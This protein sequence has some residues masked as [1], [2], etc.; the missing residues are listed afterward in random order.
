MGTAATYPDGRKY[1]RCLRDRTN[2][3]FTRFAKF[4]LRNSGRILNRL[5]IGFRIRRK[6]G[7]PQLKGPQILFVEQMKIV[8]QSY[9]RANQK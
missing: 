7:K 1:G 4:M 6:T 3:R 5:E 2:E 8:R 9:R